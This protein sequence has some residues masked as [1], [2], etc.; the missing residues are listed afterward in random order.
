MTF[1]FCLM[2]AAS[3]P[4]ASTVKSIAIRVSR[5]WAGTLF[6]SD[7][8]RSDRG[9]RT[10]DRQ[11]TGHFHGDTRCLFAQPGL[12]LRRKT[13]AGSSGFYWAGCAKE[14]D[15]S[16]PLSPVLQK[17]Q[18]SDKLF[19]ITTCAEVQDMKVLLMV[20]AAF[21]LIALGF[22][23]IESVFAAQTLPAV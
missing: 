3:S 20:T 4:R 23:V 19:I 1:S 17:T 22:A 7:G 21:C 8:D 11:I 15:R 10:T 16:K 12:F 18:Q 14:P 2:Q 5:A 9:S 13:D 6:T